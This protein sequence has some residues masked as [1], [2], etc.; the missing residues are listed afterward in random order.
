MSPPNLRPRA[1]RALI[2]AFSEAGDIERFAEEPVAL[3]KSPDRSLVNDAVVLSCAAV[4]A[5]M[6]AALVPVL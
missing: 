2:N 5:G 4:A 6:V 1:E 3:L